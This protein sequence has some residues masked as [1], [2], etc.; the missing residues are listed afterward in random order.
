MKIIL[1]GKE[2]D[3]ANLAKVTLLDALELKKQAGMSL[4]DIEEGMKTADDV[5]ILEDEA[6]LKAL[7]AFIWL[8]RRR[9]GESIT[10]AEAA[11]VPMADISFVDD[12]APE[13]PANP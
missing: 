1:E 11:N 9:A 12:E 7:I 13:E 8:T 4:A 3:A 5:S 2:Y 6:A 10:F